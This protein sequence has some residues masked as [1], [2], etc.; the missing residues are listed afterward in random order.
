MSKFVANGLFIGADVV[1]TRTLA[2][3]SPTGVVLSSALQLARWTGAE[4]MAQHLVGRLAT[5]SAQ[6]DI[7]GLANVVGIALEGSQKPPAEPDSA[8][9][10]HKRRWSR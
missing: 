8:S 4:T 10:N 1:I 2:G 3:S 7:T 6:A 9:A 5:G